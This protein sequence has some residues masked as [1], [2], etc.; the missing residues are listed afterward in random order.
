MEKKTKTVSKILVGGIVVVLAALGSY[1]C[2][3]KHEEE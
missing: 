1:L 2:Y 3:K